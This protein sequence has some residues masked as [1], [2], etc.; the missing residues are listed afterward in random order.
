MPSLPRLTRS[1]RQLARLLAIAL[2][3]LCAAA[4]AEPPNRPEVLWAA[5]QVVF[6]A[7]PSTGAVHAVGIR[8]GV[9]EFG[10]LRAPQRRAV[11]QLA[12]DPAR[13]VL[14]VTGDD[15]VYHYDART[16]RLI[17]REAATFAR[18]PQA[19]GVEGKSQ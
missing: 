9:S 4:K 12:L 16:L 5:R 1:F 14:S 10:V 11:R 3:G 15:A 7:E 19:Q 2:P 17:R 13:A 18:A 6:W 8:N